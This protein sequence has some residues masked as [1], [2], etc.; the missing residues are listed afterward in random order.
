MTTVFLALGSNVGDSQR[1]I[2]QATRLLE[3]KIS[4]LK[5]APNYTS[6]AVGFTQQAD[7]TNTAVRGETDLTPAELLQFVKSIEQELGRVH[8]FVNGPRE[9]DIDIIFYGDQVIDTP[10]LKIPHPSF[11]ER[12]FVLRPIADIEPS[13]RDPLSGRTVKGLLEAFPP[14]ALTIL[15]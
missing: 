2:A 8:R 3:S 6:K 4:L 9:I 15:Q 10:E 11:A 7:F 14:T 13:V 5:S 12:D 1:Y